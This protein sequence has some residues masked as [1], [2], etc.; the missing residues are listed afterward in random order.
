M[1]IAYLSHSVV[2][3]RA[4]NSV[5]VMKMCEAFAA[6]GHE[7]RLVAQRPDGDLAGTDPFA[8][9]GIDPSFEVVSPRRVA[10][11]GYSLLYGLL[12]ARLARAFDP[13][14]VF[15]RSVPGGYAATRLGLPVV[16]EAHSPPKSAPHISWMADRLL[17]SRHLLSLVTISEALA[18]YYT[19]DY[20]FEGHVVVAHDAA[21]DPFGDGDDRSGAPTDDR[22]GDLTDD[23]S[24]DLTDD[25]SGAPTD[26]PSPDTRRDS[27]H[28][29]Y[30][31]HL[32]PGKGMETIADLVRACPWAEFHVVGGNDEDVERWRTD[33]GDAANVRFYGFVPH[34]ETAAYRQSFDVLL[35][36]YRRQVFGTSGDVDLARWMSPL[37]LFEYMAAGKPI[38]CSDLPVLREVLTDGETAL[39]PAPED[40]EAWVGALTRLRDD[41]ALRERLGRSARRVFESGHT[42]DRRAATVLDAMAPGRA[43]LSSEGGSHS[44]RDSSE[45]VDGTAPPGSEPTAGISTSPAPLAGDG[46][47]GR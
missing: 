43:S 6:A 18:D 9:Y 12:A 5:Q 4:A 22:S 10:V 19:D 17:A 24:G 2:P 32:Y 30:I 29:G 36:P 11:K 42:W 35:A 25:R 34:A 26:G 46:G 7:V 28:V 39:L 38:V 31:G 33:L 37:K 47:E 40:T 27:L 14:V 16:F 8:F 21:D 20:G 15:C 13:D 3:S 45:E 23:R 44:G 1:K 41:P